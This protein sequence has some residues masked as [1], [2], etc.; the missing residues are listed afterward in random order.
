M[1]D[2]PDAQILNDEIR[3]WIGRTNEPEQAAMT[4]AEMQRYAHAVALG[5]VDPLHAD[6]DAAAD[7]PYGG[8]VAPFLFF[9]IP[10]GQMARTEDLGED[11]IPQSGAG[12]RLRAPIP[13]PRT[14]AGG[15]E[16]EYLR[17]VRPGDVLTRQSRIRDIWERA[18]QSGPLVF[19]AT[20]TTYRD[21]SGEPVVIVTSTT[22]SR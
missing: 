11:G 12:N 19:T 21:A 4:A 2:A 6:P 10:F 18:G 17:P 8:V 9:Q 14:M 20:E 5:P 16:V 13:L 15:T 3:S 1:A 22:I 7:S